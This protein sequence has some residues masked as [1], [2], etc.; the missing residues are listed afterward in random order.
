MSDFL[1]T[2][3]TE[4]KNCGTHT[5]TAKTVKSV[6]DNN[7]LLVLVISL[8]DVTVF[9]VFMCLPQFLAPVFVIFYRLRTLSRWSAS[10]PQPSNSVGR[11]AGGRGAAARL[12]LG[13]AGAARAAAARV[14]DAFLKF[15]RPFIPVRKLTSVSGG[16]FCRV[17]VC[18]RATR[19]THAST[20]F[21]QGNVISIWRG[22]SSCCDC[23]VTRRRIYAVKHCSIKYR[24]DGNK[25]WLRCLRN[26][27]HS[28][29]AV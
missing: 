21:Q 15:K 25:T 28:A 16:L 27:R 24:R 13:S 6:L 1:K 23:H 14:G 4:A 11:S 10:A 18:S 8:R 22:C 26:K 12:A 19:R 29:N 5:K 7:I 9:A 20:G 17:L 3:K 2:V